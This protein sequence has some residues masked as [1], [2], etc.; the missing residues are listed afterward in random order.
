MW[1][2][3]A[4]RVLVETN[5]GKT[6]SGPNDVTQK[7]G[8]TMQTGWG[9]VTNSHSEKFSKKKKVLMVPVIVRKPD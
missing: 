5:S 2:E 9:K 4:L 6:S 7:R 8:F 3:R 1:G